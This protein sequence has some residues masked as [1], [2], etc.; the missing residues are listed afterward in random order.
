[1]DGGFPFRSVP[2]R[3]HK[4][5]FKFQLCATPCICLA[6][7]SSCCLALGCD[8]SLKPVHSRFLALS[9]SEHVLN[10]QFVTTSF[11]NLF[12]YKTFHIRL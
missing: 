8:C 9:A 11:R 1:M 2:L 12:E 5:I 3:V 4:T 7:F 10:A 6:L